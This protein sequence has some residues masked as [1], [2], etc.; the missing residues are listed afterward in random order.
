MPAAPAHQRIYEDLH[1]KIESGELPAGT[2]LASQ[3]KLAEEW[4]CSLAPV[5][6]ALMRLEL[7][8]FIESRQGVGAFVLARE[9]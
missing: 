9:V 6:Q 2:Q 1:R 3:A 4:H 7:E 8:G 5:R